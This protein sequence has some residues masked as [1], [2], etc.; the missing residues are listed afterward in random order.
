[1]EWQSQ[2]QLRLS[3]PNV[4]L[5]NA[6]RHLYSQWCRCNFVPESSKKQ[7]GEQSIKYLLENQLAVKQKQTGKNTQMKTRFLKNA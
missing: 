4:L 7:G 5:A 3:D 1:M 6:Q 2:V